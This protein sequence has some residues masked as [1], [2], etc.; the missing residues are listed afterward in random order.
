MVAQTAPGWSPG[1]NAAG[2]NTYDGYIDWPLAGASF[3]ANVG[4]PLNGWVVD[5]TAEGWAGID[6]VHVYDGTAG[7]GGTFLGQALAALNR[8]DVGMVL[9]NGFWSAS[10]FFLDLPPNT[11]SVGPHTLTVYAHT[12]A[13]GWWSKQVAITI[14]RPSYKDD[15]LTVI[16]AP[17]AGETVKTDKEYT[18]TGYSL[19]RNADPTQ[20]RGVDRVQIWLGGPRDTAGSWLLGEA[21]LGLESGPAAAY[22]GQFSKAG[23]QLTFNPTKFHADNYFLYVYARSSIRGKESVTTVQFKIAEP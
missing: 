23:W 16:T 11:L 7:E 17:Q 21:T 14:T 10:G 9:G 1:P 3:A 2:P 5:R 8:P 19:D 6:Q 12:P 20:G 18:I 15:P 22:G 4:I 13:K